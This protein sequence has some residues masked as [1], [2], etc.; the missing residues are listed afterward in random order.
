MDKYAFM[1]DCGK[2]RYLLS[3][4]WDEN[5]PMV[6]FIGLNPSR[7]DH[8]KNDPT[9]TRCEGFGKSW[10]YGGL[11]FANLY[12]WRT[13]YPENLIKHLPEAVGPD[14]N[15]NLRYMIG[16][17][18]KVV[19]AWGSWKFINERVKEVMTL[20]NEPYCF[21]LNK[22]GQPKHPL[23]LKSTTPLQKF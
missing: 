23:Y 10:G 3:R 14:C 7:A 20:I 6:M 1:S 15:D 2:H 9:I 11:Y 22:D 16:F 17:S 13:P 19:C 5:K 18:D 8:I 12:S 21:G 4:I